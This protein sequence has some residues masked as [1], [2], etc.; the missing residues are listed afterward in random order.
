MKNTPKS[1]HVL[2]ANEPLA[3]REVI[4]AAFE[5]LRPHVRVHATEPTDLDKEFLRLSP[6]LVVCSRTTALIEHEAPAWVELY[7]DHASRTV[8]SLAGEKTVFD[9]MDFDTLLS[10]LDEAERLYGIV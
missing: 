4:S 8:A 10:I 6:K 2:V 7:P 1:I 3:Y 9:A 5:E